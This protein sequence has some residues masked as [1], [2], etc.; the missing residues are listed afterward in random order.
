MQWYV[1]WRPNFVSDAP[2]IPAQLED[3]RSNMSILYNQL[4]DCFSLAKVSLVKVT[5]LESRS[6]SLQT[7]QRQNRTIRAVNNVH[8]LM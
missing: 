8:S 3:E 4:N 6:P 5:S 2:S 7:L 1:A